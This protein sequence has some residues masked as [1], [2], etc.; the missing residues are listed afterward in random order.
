LQF[1]GPVWI[2]T[3]DS[4]VKRFESPK[5]TIRERRLLDA[6]GITN[7]PSAVDYDPKAVKRMRGEIRK[8][9]PTR[10]LRRRE[11]IEIDTL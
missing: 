9:F 5:V 6:L 4:N 1:K 7:L 11:R 2:S 3:S 10:F 8:R